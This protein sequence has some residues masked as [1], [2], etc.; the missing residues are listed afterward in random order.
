MTN[1][2]PSHRKLLRK[3]QGGK[4]CYCGIK[5]RNPQAG[6]QQFPDSETI[7]HLRRRADG[8]DNSLNNKA[9]ACFRCNVERGEIDWL[10]YKSFRMGE[11]FFCHPHETPADP[12][13]QRV[14]A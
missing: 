6:G 14:A 12:P 8:G 2:T 1:L 5:M 7:E 11:V 9:L 4:C 10:T 3:A 13:R